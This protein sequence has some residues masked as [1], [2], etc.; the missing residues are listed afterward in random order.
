[1]L[2]EQMFVIQEGMDCVLL[3]SSYHILLFASGVEGWGWMTQTQ[4]LSIAVQHTHNQVR[5]LVVLHPLYTSLSDYAKCKAV[6]TQA[7]YIPFTE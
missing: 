1:M 6:E 7:Q 5:V 3:C 2:S 4:T